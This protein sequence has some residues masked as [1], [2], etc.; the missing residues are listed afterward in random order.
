VSE[1]LLV[2]EDDRFIQ[3]KLVRLLSLEGYETLAVD[4][5][6]EALDLLQS[7]NIDMIILDL[8]LPGM[9]GITA[10][11]RIRQTWTAPLLMLTARAD[12]SDKALGL[13]SGA[14]DYLAKPFEATELVARVRALLRP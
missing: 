11:R 5:G 2:V 4:S 9:D 3:D 1:T 10:C 14:D 7:K 12:A 6:E 8:G 13:A